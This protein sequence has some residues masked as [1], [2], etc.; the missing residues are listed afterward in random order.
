M[1]TRTPIILLLFALC[2]GCHQ[3]EAQK[4]LNE[5]MDTVKVIRDAN[6]VESYS[7]IPDS[8]KGKLDTMTLAYIAFACDCPNYVKL[9]SKDSI[10]QYKEAYYIQP[11]SKELIIPEVLRYDRNEFELIGILSKEYGLPT[12]FGFMDPDPPPGPIFT[13]W[14]YSVIRPYKFYGP[15]YKVIGGLNDTIELSSQIIVR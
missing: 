4:P 13:Y 5:P 12:Y 15:P 8:L 10:G 3:P 1:I 11:V 7:E 6:I 2:L 14:S 9:S